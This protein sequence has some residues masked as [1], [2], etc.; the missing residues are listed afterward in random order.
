MTDPDRSDSTIPLPVAPGP[1][2]GQS[3]DA[4]AP[5]WPIPGVILAGRYRL[6]TFCGSEPHIQFWQGL[7]LATGQL[8][9]LSLVDVD[10]N[11]PLEHVNEI[12]SLSVR[13]RGLDVSG[14]ARNL[15][16]LH[17]GEFGL[18]VNE[19]VPGGSL[20]E[21]ADTAPSPTAV[22]AAL[23]PLI[24]AADAAHHAGSTLSI[25]S[26]SRIRISSNGRAMLAFAAAMPDT[27]PRDDL[28]GI[29]GVFYALLIDRWPAQDMVPTG[30]APADFDD[31][32]WPKEP[33]AIDRRIPFLISSAAA[34]LLRPEGGVESAST[35]LSLLRQA[36]Q[37]ARGSTVT[38]TQIEALLPGAYARF[39]NVDP[40]EEVKRFRRQAMKAVLA[41]AAVTF[42]VAVTSLGSSLNQVL[43]DNDD[44]VAMDA[45]RLGLGP[46]AGVP[47][48]PPP[49]EVA[50]PS[51][52]A[53]VVPITA[54]VFSPDGSPDNPDAAGKAIDRDP[55]SAWAT[56]RYYD[57]DP[58]PKFKQGLG[59]LLQLPAPAVLTSLTIN[60]KGTGT[61]VQIRS[62]AT[63]NPVA[64]SDTEEISAP[65]PM[66]PGPNRVVLS[67][68]QQVSNVLVW[69]STLG[70]TDG[71]NRAEISDITLATMARA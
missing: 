11:L 47:V 21:V 1:V 46:S 5:R 19:W 14:I 15:D 55:A 39:R 44:V 18:V 38:R 66:Q 52:D 10:G 71:Q 65:T 64:L 17:T 3:A 24:V 63:D 68:A 30:W 57:A 34:G 23:K 29:G 2:R 54:S 8:V 67:R 60:L 51:A 27:T 13:L 45:D 61:V 59:L 50:Q 28:R 6:L 16:V 53:P 70:S 20:R 32:G 62:A 36:E 41:A 48:A 12:L 7:D 49:S 4:D 58:F 25:S 26:P 69:I 43:G 9:G 35:L 33:A 56:D 37:D 22:A 40:A 42:L 31:A